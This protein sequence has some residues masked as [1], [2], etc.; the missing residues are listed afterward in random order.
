MKVKRDMEDILGQFY[1]N[2]DKLTRIGTI[3]VSELSKVD[4]EL[5][6]FYHKMEGVHLSHNTQA[7]VHMKEL[8]DILSRRRKW[9]KDIILV[10]SFLDSTKP[11]ME[12]AKKRTTKAIKTHD[13]MMRNIQNQKSLKKV[14]K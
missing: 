7:H 4:I 8:Q 6:E 2:Y 11:S 5:S 10:N 12:V 3:A 9:K 13:K 14:T 1:Q